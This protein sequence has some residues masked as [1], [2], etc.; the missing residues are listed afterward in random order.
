MSTAVKIR[1][2]GNA[3]AVTLPREQLD[4]LGLSKGDRVHLVETPE[5]LLLTPFDPAF[6]DAMA[7]YDRVASRYRDALHELAK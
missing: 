1:Q 2:T 6:E 4:R 5:G 7:A 3:L